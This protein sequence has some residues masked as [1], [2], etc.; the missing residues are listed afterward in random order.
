MD[1]TKNETS[2]NESNKKIEKLMENLK[3]KIEPTEAQFDNLKNIAEQYSGKS[4]NEIFFEIIKLNKKFSEEMSKEEYEEKLKKL[5][6]IR[7][8]LSEEQSRKLDK[9]LEV[10]KKSE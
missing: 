4:D 9:I 7:P 3:D 5:E 6:T 10:L 1:N 2:S 8:L